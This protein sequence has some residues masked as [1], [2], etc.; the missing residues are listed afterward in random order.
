[1]KKRLSLF[2]IL[3]SLI[4]V[5]HAQMPD[6]SKKPL[7]PVNG[8]DPDKVN[9]EPIYTSVETLPKFPG[10][11][12]SLHRYL[13]ASLVY[14]ADLIKAHVGG[15]VIVN[16]VVEKDG[17]L[18]QLKVFRSPDDR[19]TAELIKVFQAMQFIPGQQNGHI[20]RVL[21]SVPVTFDWRKPGKF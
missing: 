16:F 3:I 20:V 18:V 10:G 17:S 11:V 1:M 7:L 15:T 21:Y 12:D 4:S 6:T 9:N 13:S 19:I 5:A 14:P 2:L 8:L